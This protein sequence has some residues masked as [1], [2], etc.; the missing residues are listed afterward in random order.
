MVRF[1]PVVRHEMLHAL[2][3]V[4]GHPREA[5]IDRCLGVVSC[6]GDCLEE[7]GGEP[8]RDPEAL[9]VDPSAL[10]IETWIEPGT[11]SLSA[12]TRGCL[13][14]VVKATNSQTTPV[15]VRLRGGHAGI[16]NQSF[17]WSVEDYGGGGVP[18]PDSLMGFAAGETRRHTFDCAFVG[19]QSESWSGLE[20][21]R[22]VLRG[23][24]RD[25]YSDAP[26]TIVP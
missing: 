7:G 17:S 23:H 11:V 5:F 14:V 6:I 20:P 25:N 26:F 21:G 24:V 13:P 4:G 8:A 1:G 3:R 9:V 12:G 22:Y 19:K 10:T 15:R 2:L 16:T 18:E